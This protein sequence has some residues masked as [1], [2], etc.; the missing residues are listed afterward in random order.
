M[1]PHFPERLN[2]IEKKG[3][4]DDERTA[5]PGLSDM[6]SALTFLKPGEEQREVIIS[7]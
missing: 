3:P 6:S 5:P 4:A 7:R 2:K 1:S